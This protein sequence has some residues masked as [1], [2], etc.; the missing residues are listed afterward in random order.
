VP[1][2]TPTGEM[3]PETYVGYSRLQYLA[4][5]TGVTQN[6]PAPYHFPAHLSLGTLGLSGT[7][8]VHAEEATAGTGAELE[9]G[10]PGSGILGS[11]NEP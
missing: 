11:V 8:T 7:W 4:S 6:R 1:N 10:F 3:N 9:L 5:N 2:L